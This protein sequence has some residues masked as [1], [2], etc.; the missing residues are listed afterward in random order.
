MNPIQLFEYGKSRGVAIQPNTFIGNM[1]STYPTA[2]DLAIKLSISEVDIT[3]YALVGND[4]EA[5]IEVSYGFG[6]ANSWLGVGITYYLDFDGLINS[7]PRSGFQSNLNLR[8]FYSTSFS[9]TWGTFCFRQTGTNTGG[10]GTIFE[11]PNLTS[12]GNTVFEQCTFGVLYLPN[13]VTFGDT[14]A[15]ET[16]FASVAKPPFR[17]SWVYLHPSFDGSSEADY[18]YLLG[19]GFTPAFVSN[20]N[21]PP[22]I[23]SGNIIPYSTVM[24]L[25]SP[26]SSPNPVD[27]YEVY[28]DEVYYGKVF[29]GELVEGLQYSTTY[30]IKVITVDTLYNKSQLSPA[31]SVTT[32][33]AQDA[34]HEYETALYAD[35]INASLGEIK[36][37]GKI[38]LIIKKLKEHSLYTKTIHFTQYNYGG[39]R[40]NGSDL[41][42]RA[43]SLDSNKI[44]IYQSTTANKPLYVANGIRFDSTDRLDQSTLLTPDTPIAGKSFT[45]MWKFKPTVII[46]YGNQVNLSASGGWSAFIVHA[47][48]SGAG[49]WGTTTYK[50]LP[51]N[52][53][54]ANVDNEFSFTYDWDAQ[55]GTIY[56][57]TTLWK[58]EAMLRP[59]DNF[60]IKILQM[61]GEVNYLA[62]FSEKLTVAQ[63]GELQTLNN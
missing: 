15:N 27:Y 32:L 7:I 9:I 44:D 55:M 60:R 37:K 10:K 47:V 57:G 42:D 53:F 2:S 52:T 49:N 13:V 12:I 34:T 8:R 33:A 24:L 54:I 35:R 46:Q 61:G 1:G 50:S 29:P 5:R 18:T 39:L 51:A 38:D 62:A 36:D 48:S 19:R 45:V 22:V 11:F 41:I 26:V 56:K 63:I 16:V 14:T 43:Y 23:V 17:N 58:T 59:S 40:R 3:Y 6:G 21:I 20:Y 4:I 31:I 25:N 28:I 30:Q